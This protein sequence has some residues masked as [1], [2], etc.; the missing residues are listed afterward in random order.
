MST[1]TLKNTDTKTVNTKT[2]EFI[3]N[4]FSFNDSLKLF[5]WHVTGTGSY[6]KHMALDEAIATLLGVTDRL[7]ETTYAME[8]DVAITIPATKTPNDIVK[9]A[10]GFYSFV[11]DHRELFTEAFTQSIIDDYQEGIQQLIYRL[12]RLQ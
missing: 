6:A 3:G 12:K 11:E 7:V 2:A 4:I 9:H 5:H 10:E 8:G 1:A